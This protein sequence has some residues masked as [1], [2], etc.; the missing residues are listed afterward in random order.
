MAETITYTESLTTTR[1]WCGISLAIPSNLLTNCRDHNSPSSLYCPLG[2][3]FGWHETKADRLAKELE[4]KERLLASRQAQLDQAR[5]EADHQA[6]VARGYKGAAAKAKKRA[7]KGVCPA[8]GC[9]RSFVDVAR[10]V[11]TCHPELAEVQP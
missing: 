10:H 5:A 2:H 4:R 3:T 11:T 6:A 7:A 8:P 1:C 9:K